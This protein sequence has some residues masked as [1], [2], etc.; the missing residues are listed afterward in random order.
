M[1]IIV[2]L[3]IMTRFIYLLF[4]IV[5][6]LAVSQSYTA[7]NYYL[8]DSV[9]ITEI[10]VS[11]QTW[12][13]SIFEIDGSVMYAKEPGTV[14]FEVNTDGTTNFNQIVID[15]P[16][17]T[18]RDDA[19]SVG[20]SWT[21]DSLLAT[22]TDKCSCV[23]SVEWEFVQN[24]GGY[25][26]IFADD[27]FSV[28]VLNKQANADYVYL[29]GAVSFHSGEVENVLYKIEQQSQQ[30]IQMT[31]FVIDTID[32]GLDENVT[33]EELFL[34]LGVEWGVE[35]S[36]AAK[37]WQ[38]TDSTI[39]YVDE[40]GTIILNEKGEVKL[41]S[42]SESPN[43]T[44]DEITL[45][46]SALTSVP[47]GVITIHDKLVD[48]NVGESKQLDYD[49]NGNVLPILWESDNPSVAIVDNQGKVRATGIGQT[50]IRAKS[51]LNP[52]VFSLSFITVT[53][54]V[55]QSV[56]L[57]LESVEILEM[58]S[59]SF[60]AT[61]LPEN[62]YDKRIVWEVSDNSLATVSKGLLSVFEI[63]EFDLYVYSEVDNTVADTMHVTVLRDPELYHTAEIGVG[64]YSMLGQLFPEV[65][66]DG[67]VSFTGVAA[68]LSTAPVNKQKILH[69]LDTGSVLIEVGFGDRIVS[70][71]LLINVVD[72]YVPE[73]MPLVVDLKFA[74]FE[75]IVVSLD[76]KIDES[77]IQEEF[78]SLTKLKSIEDPIY[79]ERIYVLPDEENAFAIELNRTWESGE[80]IKIASQPGIYTEDGR[81]VAFEMTL[82]QEVVGVD[83]MYEKI[84]VRYRNGQIIF[85]TSEEVC[86]FQLT[87]ILGNQRYFPSGDNNRFNVTV[88][89]A[90]VYFVRFSVNGVV[91]SRKLLIR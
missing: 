37:I 69:G 72:D 83:E 1:K 63:G 87:N 38:S 7:G 74:G 73:E 45:R 79:I 23:N 53:D 31:S 58:S 32:V 84:P 41:W 48:L 42:Y 4:V 40:G 59:V 6:F 43:K 55:P 46:V 54:V 82:G 50:K 17:S 66:F 51:T 19:F 91:L 80:L 71:R 27:E 18:G 68:S 47:T 70:S 90:G 8:L 44:Q 11:N 67:Q 14:V 22:F 26:L 89:P 15:E 33:L 49:V 3:T 39:A 35:T 29:L 85:E 61:V 34:L 28:F 56:S 64:Y 76:Y 20:F 52:D 21:A 75:T 86:C 2:K 88:L 81:A 13:T 57:G 24:P 16:K 78:I 77:T 12:D 5:P 62:A 9:L 25:E 10:E 36:D 30:G 65:D 60:S